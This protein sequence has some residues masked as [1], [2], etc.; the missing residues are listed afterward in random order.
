MQ[1][2]FLSH[3]KHIDEDTGCRYRYI[4][5]ESERFLLHR[6]DFYEIFITVNKKIVHIVNG[7]KQH[8]AV[9]SMVFVRPR[10]I[11]SYE[12]KPGNQ[13]NFVN[14]AFDKK[15]M[16]DIIKYIDGCFDINS[17]L[18]RK[19]PPVVI[20]S[21]TEKKNLL[22]KL[23]ELN[24]INRSDRKR[25]K[26]QLRLLLLDIFVR[27]FSNNQISTNENVP[28]WFE[29]M[30][31]QMK[32]QV[33]FAEGITKMEEISHKSRE[34]IARCMRKYKGI[35]PTE[36]INDIRLNYIA[37]MLANS[38]TPI[39]DLCFE[40]GFKSVSWFYTLFKEKYGLSPAQF[41]KQ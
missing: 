41:R 2:K 11:H 29:N 8:L 13:Y 30:C 40:S 37:N 3:K 7:E 15:T 33:N 31:E 4:F 36:F 14:L 28:Y 22:S 34:H 6:H 27:Y 24:Y 25:L 38:N 9:G 26:L 20:L 16:D 5:S 19:L 12:Y 32:K 23:S 39:L 17:L 10:D 18:E 1:A 21:P 35:T